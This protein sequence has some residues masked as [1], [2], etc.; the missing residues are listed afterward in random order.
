VVLKCTVSI[1]VEEKPHFMLILDLYFTLEGSEGDFQLRNN[2]LKT[3]MLNCFSKVYTRKS[4]SLLQISTLVD[5]GYFLVQPMHDIE[6]GLG[7]PRLL[8]MQQSVW[9][10]VCDILLAL[11]KHFGYLY[12][13]FLLR[14]VSFSCM[15]GKLMWILFP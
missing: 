9:V 2:Q 1:D 7:K 15:R 3:V 4:A 6:P 13:L 5:E 10:V 12:I 14:L 11:V 8:L